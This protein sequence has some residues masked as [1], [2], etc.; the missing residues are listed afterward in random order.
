[1]KVTFGVTG[2]YDQILMNFRIQDWHKQSH[3][4]V[5]SVDKFDDVCFSNFLVYYDFW[6]KLD[7]EQ[8]IFL[9]VHF[10]KDTLPRKTELHCNFIFCYSNEYEKV[11]G[12]HFRRFF[13]DHKQFYEKNEKLCQCKPMSYLKAKK[14]LKF[15]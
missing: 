14:Q 9:C 8:P 6:T 1:M 11:E 13:Q 12:K 5:Q 7:P 15:L 3:I 4:L 10:P 2:T